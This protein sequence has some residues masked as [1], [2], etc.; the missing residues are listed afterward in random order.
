MKRCSNPKNLQV[1]YEKN[2]A[3][4]I[5]QVKGDGVE[6]GG[7]GFRSLIVDHDS[8]VQV[9]NNKSITL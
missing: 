5:E 1:E 8:N 7:V 3:N 2:V 4:V 6:D 9:D